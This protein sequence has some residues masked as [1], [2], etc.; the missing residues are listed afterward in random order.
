M[1]RLACIAIVAVTGCSEWELNSHADL[2]NLPGPN[3]VVAPPALQYAML[4]SG[5][6]EVQSFTISND[7]DAPLDVSDIRVATGLAFT[8][9]TPQVEYLIEVGDTVK[10]DVGFSPVSTMDFG[11]VLVYS[12]DPD[13]P[14]VPVDLSG[15][16]AVPQLEITPN[17]HDFGPTAI[18]CGDQVEVFLNSIG[19]EDLTITDLDF[20]SGGLLTIDD[21]RV[22]EVLP[23]TLEPGKAASV[24]VNLSAVDIGADTGTLSV[25]S[26]DP[27][28]VVTAD[29]T[30]EG[31]YSDA[32]TEQFLEPDVPPVDVMFLIDQS[33]S[34]EQD[35]QY[36][37][38]IM[39]EY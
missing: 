16:G 6:T 5:E 34:M 25:T 3:I 35:R 37:L 36:F 26:N 29:Q 22:Q 38:E 21:A 39:I 18:P 17:F 24:W 1:T 9:L 12:D 32:T 7:G 4:S 8:L 11:Q 27:R 2:D 30:A 28:G 23:L 13:S 10:I 19:A 20:L 31:F 33:C 14:E 15:Q